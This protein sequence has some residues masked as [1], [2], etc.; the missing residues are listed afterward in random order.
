MLQFMQLVL[1][2]LQMAKRGQRRFMHSR[3]RL[4]V[5]MLRQ[6]SELEPARPRNFAAIRSLF[7]V[8]Q[9]ENRGLARA[10]ASDQTDVLTRIDLK[11]RA[12]QN[13]LRAE[14]L[15]TAVKRN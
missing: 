6:Q 15:V 8:Y 13:S 11:R 9:T 2:L 12:A 4:E 5:N 3:A 14:E 10:V 7:F 1:D